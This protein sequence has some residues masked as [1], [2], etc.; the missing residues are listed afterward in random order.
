MTLRTLRHPG[1][2]AP[3]RWQAVPCR[4]E[5]VRV[6][7]RAGLRFGEA[8]ARGLAETGHDAGY[9]CLSDVA[10]ARLSYV[11]PA[12]APGD[13]HAAWYSAVRTIPDAPRITTGGVHLGRRDG[14]PFTHCH[15]VWRGEQ[16]PAA[17]GH[18]LP[19]DCILLTDCEVSGWGLTGAGLVAEH[20]PE[21][22]FT[23]FRPRADGA[24]GKPDAFLCRVRPNQD[25]SA[26]LTALAA[27]LGVNDAEIAGIGSLVGTCFTEGP[28]I[29]P[30][31]TEVLLTR[32]RIRAGVPDLAALSVGFDGIFREGDLRPGRNAVCVTAELLIRALYS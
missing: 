25:I 32:G 20:D 19:D 5:P 13:G 16:T 2:V 27:D 18:L 21:T 30:Y 17:M 3:E 23:L 11:I 7:L 22:A 12:P 31:A 1:P 24:S 29:T 9:L 4:A 6:R 8:V 26:A 15:G 10:M 28:A 14:A